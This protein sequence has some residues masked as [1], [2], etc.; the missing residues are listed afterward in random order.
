MSTLELTIHEPN[1]K[2]KLFLRDKHS[3]IA[4]G[5]ARGGGKSWAVRVKAVLLALHY[6]GIKLMIIRR[7]YPEL[8]ENHIQPLIE[9]LRCYDPDKNNR[10]ASYNDQKKVMTFITGSRLLF[11]Y[12]EKPKDAS[13]F[14]GTEVDV[15]F[16]DEATHQTWGNV[17]KLIACVRGAN[18]FPKRVYFTCNPGGPGHAWVKRL[19]I[20]RQ[21][22]DGENPEDYR[23]IKALVTDN[24]A[25]MQEDPGYLRTLQALTPKLRKAWL[26]GDWTVLEGQFF[27]EFRET[28]DVYAAH[29]A[30]VEADADTLRKERRWTHVIDPFEIPS[31]WKIYRSF[32]WGYA[33]PFSCA[34]WAMDYDGVLYRILE[35]YGCTET[36]NEGVKWPPDKVFAQIRKTEREHRWLKGKRIQGVA[37]PAIWNA[38]HGESIE[39]TARK[40]GIYFLPG[41]HKRIPGWMQIHYRMSFDE[42]GF[43]MMYVFSNCKAFIRTIPLLQYD[44]VMVEDL[45]TDGE[46]HVADETRYMLMTRPI[47][48]R[49]RPKDS[50]P[51]PDALKLIL[52]IDKDDLPPASRRQRMEVIEDG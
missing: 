39:E 50:T 1:E 27:E 52:D 34:W 2:Q 9:M 45:D 3:Y 22:R 13:R 15:L 33:K 38:E 41:D 5:G 36:P 48:P 21:Y 46:D 11:R 14:Q 12:C 40:N 6:P 44:D 32:D 18:S 28:P 8:N 35:M 31:G 29:A 16:I 24:K 7:T 26:E 30:G 42:N 19:F 43:P 23:F 51:E 20:D 49:Q 17:E 10:I 47:P 25:L 4:Y 37:D